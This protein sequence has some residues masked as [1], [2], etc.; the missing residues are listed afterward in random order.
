M[1]LNNRQE[2]QSSEERNSWWIFFSFWGSL[3][4]LRLTLNSVYNQEWPWTRVLLP[5]PPRYSRHALPGKVCPLCLLRAQPLSTFFLNRECFRVRFFHISKLFINSILAVYS[6]SITN[7]TAVN[8][9]RMLRKK[10]E[11]IKLQWQSTHQNTV[12]IFQ[13]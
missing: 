10:T 3:T 8:V 7:S 12:L 5:P 1:R 13:L 4:C 6:F 11:F 9:L 2:E